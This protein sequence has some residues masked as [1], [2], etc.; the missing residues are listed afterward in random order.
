MKIITVVTFLI[1]VMTCN[2]FAGEQSQQKVDPSHKHGVCNE[3][4]KGVD[5]LLYEN[6]R[7]HGATTTC[8]YADDRLLIKPKSTLN[9]ERMNRFVFLTFSIA[10]ALRNDDFILPNQV[11]V[12]YGSACQVLTTNDAAEL[13]KS[14]KYGG[15]SG[16]RSARIWAL[17]AKKV[18]CPK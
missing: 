9:P 8:S 15:D 2:G 1:L 3:I 11:Y 6:S 13:Q 18:L 16:M 7:L 10:G 17:N 14:A 5:S 12:G 4:K